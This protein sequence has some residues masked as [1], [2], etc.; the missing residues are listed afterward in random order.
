MIAVKDGQLVGVAGL[1]ILWDDLAEV[2]SV[3]VHPDYV[4]LGIGGELV[5]RLEEEGRELGLEKVFVLTYQ[6]EFFSQLGY[7]I[8]QQAELPQKVWMECVNCPKFPN[9][10]ELAMIKAL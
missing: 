2:R 6:E 3:A 1:H 10:D 8:V 7:K 4:K 5:T 9:C